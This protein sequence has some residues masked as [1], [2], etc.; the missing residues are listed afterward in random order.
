MKTI[1]PLKYEQAL[2][3]FLQALPEEGLVLELNSGTGQ[4]SQRIVEKGYELIVAE[5][6]ETQFRIENS[7]AKETFYN[8][9]DKLLFPFKTFSGIWAHQSFIHYEPEQLK[10][11]F[12]HMVD[13]LVQDGVFSLSFIEGEGKKEIH[14][15]MP[16]SQEKQVLVYYQPEVLASLLESSG[17]TI[18]DAW[19]EVSRADQ[20]IIQI[21]CKA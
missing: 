21:L 16:F 20:Q 10:A 11:Y 12:D 13:W 6:Q 1:P 18:I 17:F 19:R 7:F 14:Q 4:Y 3:R 2:Q 8:S 15:Q 9:I 5:L